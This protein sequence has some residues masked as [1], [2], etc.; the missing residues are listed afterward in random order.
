MLKCSVKDG[1]RLHGILNALSYRSLVTRALIVRCLQRSLFIALSS[2]EEDDD[3]AEDDEEDEF[4]DYLRI[5]FVIS[6]CRFE[7][8]HLD[9]GKLLRR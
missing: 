8:S 5:N 1:W 9:E 7:Q 2:G 3:D 6:F 4:C